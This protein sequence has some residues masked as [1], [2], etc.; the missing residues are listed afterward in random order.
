MLAFE[1]N[2]V[3]RHIA[4]VRAEVT[5]AETGQ[6]GYIL[7]GERRYLAPYEEAV[8]RV[9]S[10]L[11]DLDTLVRAPDQRQR[12]AEMR[13]LIE[14]KFGE[15]AR[16]VELRGQSFDAALRVVRT[17]EGQRLME[18]IATRV[19]AFEQSERARLVART[20]ALESRATWATRYAGLTV[21]L[22]LGSAVIAALWFARQKTHAKLFAA[23]RGFRRDLEHQVEERTL[24]LTEANRELDAYAYT[25]SHDLR[26]PL[27]AMHGYADALS[28]DYGSLLPKEGQRFTQRIGAAAS[29]MEELIQD[30][31]SYSRLAREEV[32]LRPVSLES[33]VDGVL[34]RSAERLA[35]AGAEVHVERPLAEVTAH[36]AILGQAVENLILNAIKFTASG[37]KP[38]VRIR[39]ERHGSMVRLHVED[40]G[41]GID[42]EHQERIF[43]PFERLHG[44]ETYPGTGIGLA[45]VRRS[46]DRMGGR[47]GVN[48]TPGQ[49][50]SFWIELGRAGEE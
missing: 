4:Q 49:G 3:L 36:A 22:A 2:T 12:L 20:G 24:Q 39:A 35:E 16:T 30:I 41:I 34:A 21:L 48:S 38:K 18:E 8:T 32:R 23:E 45:I 25:I 44:A 31:L 50:S 40:N 42:L 1:T 7:T 15:L 27:R 47:S 9:W 14:A 29:Q 37:A 26:A 19:Q 5:A 43:R 46:L 33:V 10:T 17:D 11:T 28:E 13:P 6:R